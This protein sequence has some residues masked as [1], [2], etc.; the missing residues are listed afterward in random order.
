MVPLNGQELLRTIKGFVQDQSGQGLAYK[1]V[2][3]RY[4]DC[5][6]A[7]NQELVIETT[8]DVDG[9]YELQ[10]ELCQE[11]IVLIIAYC[12]EGFQSVDFQSFYEDHTEL[13]FNFDC[14]FDYNCDASF[15]Y[16][17]GEPNME[18][19]VIPFYFNA[20]NPNNEDYHYEWSFLGADDIE[21]SH[22][23]NPIAYYPTFGQYSV[24][25]QTYVVGD[26]YNV[27]CEFCETINS[28]LALATF[29]TTST[30]TTIIADDVYLYPNPVK[31]EAILAF[32]ILH[33]DEYTI[34]IINDMGQSQYLE[35]VDLNKGRHQIALNF[36]DFASGVYIVRIKSSNGQLAKK[37]VK[38]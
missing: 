9:Y 24:C 26:P 27:I 3:A 32:S 15:S 38:R 20:V 12:G 17:F 37:V 22:L 25:M 6:D 7:T 21:G 28:D 5:N 13:N 30:Q 23:D 33:R 1:K 31:D 16:T 8:S 36:N 4:H 10:I 35:K 2:E 29:G 11:E 14:N 18:D 19:G 34:E